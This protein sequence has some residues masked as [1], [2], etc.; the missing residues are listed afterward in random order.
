MVF[1]L[2]LFS[3]VLPVELEFFDAYQRYDYHLLEWKAESEEDFRE[4]EIE[5]SFDGINFDYI[6]S[7]QPNGNMFYNYL[8]YDY[9]IGYNYY[10]LKMVDLDGT[11]E[12][13]KIEVIDAPD[14]DFKFTVYPTTAR[15]GDI[16]TA[17]VN[18]E[19]I[20]F[21]VY[22]VLGAKVYDGEIDVETQLVFQYSGIFFIS[23]I[24]DQ[25]RRTMRIKI[26]E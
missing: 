20:E 10:R 2:S 21:Q 13:S 17:N 23:V 18:A 25:K 16:V 22:N 26:I 19:D 1:S 14:N 3:Q 5:Q 8:I 6:S 11:F 12:Y 24:H 7:V 9:A 4:Y 15:I